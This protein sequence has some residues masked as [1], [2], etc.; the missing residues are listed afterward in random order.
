[1]LFDAQNAGNHIFRASR[2]Q[3][4]QGEHAPRAPLIGEK[5]LAA[6]LVVTATY[7]TFSGR[8]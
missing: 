7:Y 6:P 2:F 1:M 4:F 8:L 3:I 5:G